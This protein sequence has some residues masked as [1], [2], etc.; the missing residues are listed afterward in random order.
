[1]QHDWAIAAR[2]RLC[3][4]C[5]AYATMWSTETVMNNNRNPLYDDLAALK[6]IIA[7]KP[8]DPLTMQNL[9]SCN[10]VEEFDG[11]ALLTE[12]GIQAAARIVDAD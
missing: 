6:Q 11:I 10:L 3:W 1:M 8:A 5:V 4:L 9:I 12:S 7:G 2:E